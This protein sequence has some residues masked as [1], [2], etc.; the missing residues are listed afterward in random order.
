MEIDNNHLVTRYYDLQAKNGKVFKAVEA[1]VNGQVEAVFDQLKTH[2][3]DTVTI[4]LEEAMQ[5]A[6]DAGFNIDPAELE[7]AVTNFILKDLDSIGLWIL[8]SQQSDPNTI[9]ARLNFFNHSRYY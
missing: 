5:V 7:I 6:K 1:Y 9:V 8:P 4:D 2:F 3:V